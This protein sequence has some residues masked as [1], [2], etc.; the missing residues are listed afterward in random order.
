MDDVTERWLPVP[1][2]DGA[3]EVSDLGRVRSNKLYHG[4]SR[5]LLALASDGYGY[6]QVTFSRNGKTSTRKVHQLVML[7]FVGP[8]PLGMEV[9]HGP[10]GKLDNR[11]VSLCYGTRTENIADRIRDGGQVRQRL[12]GEANGRAKLNAA[13]VS[14]IRRRLDAAEM[15]IS[16]ARSLGVGKSTIGR[17]ARGQAWNDGLV[18]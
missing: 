11:L 5:R 9:R 17:I 18:T 13:A 8:P 15:Q 6:L 16:I 3:Y 4:T 12:R 14:E 2:Y 10:R 7:A 1:G